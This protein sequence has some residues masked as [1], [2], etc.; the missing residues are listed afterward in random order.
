MEFNK[1]K[2]PIFLVRN[3]SSSFSAMTEALRLDNASSW[4]LVLPPSNR[5]GYFE[6][7]L[8]SSHHRKARLSVCKWRCITGPEQEDGKWSASHRRRGCLRGRRTTLRIATEKF[9]PFS[10]RKRNQNYKRFTR[11][12]GYLSQ[13]IYSGKLQWDVSSGYGCRYKTYSQFL[14]GFVVHCFIQNARLF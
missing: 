5:T 6:L 9:S 1:C 8:W 2:M 13:I 14:R 4:K 3:Q 7:T 10:I 12:S 11:Q